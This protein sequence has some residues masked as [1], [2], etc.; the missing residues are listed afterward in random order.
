MKGNEEQPEGA[1]NFTETKTK[2]KTASPHSTF[3]AQMKPEFV[4]LHHR[5][6]F[7]EQVKAASQPRPQRKPQRALQSGAVRVST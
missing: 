7:R 5:G 1:K 6:R 3:P 2:Q 4:G